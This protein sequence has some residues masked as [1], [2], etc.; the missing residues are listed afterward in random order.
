[1]TLKSEG[2][3]RMRRWTLFYFFQEKE[4]IKFKREMLH[5]RILNFAPRDKRGGCNDS[6]A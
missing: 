4:I 3:F 5:F 2:W 1:M 6:E